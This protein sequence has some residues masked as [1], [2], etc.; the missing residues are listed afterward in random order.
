MEE[1]IC[2]AHITPSAHDREID[3]SISLFTES[4]EFSEAFDTEIA[5]YRMTDVDGDDLA[6]EG[7]KDDVVCNEDEIEITLSVPNVRVRGG[8]DAVRDEK[9]GSERVLEALGDEGGKD[10]PIDVKNDGYEEELE[11]GRWVQ[12]SLSGGRRVKTK[13]RG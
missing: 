13:Y 4:I 12:M 5:R 2:D 10:L 3:G 1:R 6:D 11:R 9:K 7:E 8:G